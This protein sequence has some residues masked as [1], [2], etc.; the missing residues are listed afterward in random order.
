MADTGAYT[1]VIVG[2]SGYWSTGL[3]EIDAE[4]A[5]VRRRRTRKQ[6]AR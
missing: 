1:D 5:A 3:R 4:I 2:C 6:P